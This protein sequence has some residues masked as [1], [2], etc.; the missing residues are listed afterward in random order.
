MGVRE[1]LVDQIVGLL[2]GVLH[3]SILYRLSDTLC[4]STDCSIM[5]WGEHSILL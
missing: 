1:S 3:I 4:F 2:L 5:S